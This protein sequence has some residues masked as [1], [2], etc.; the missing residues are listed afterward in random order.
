MAFG[1]EKFKWQV[2]ASH[3]KRAFVWVFSLFERQILRIEPFGYAT[4]HNQVQ[5][6][7]V[8]ANLPH[9]FHVFFSRSSI[10]PVQPWR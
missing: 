2:Y 4:G 9:F 5:T 10:G 1:V 8:N 6:G 7:E 3:L